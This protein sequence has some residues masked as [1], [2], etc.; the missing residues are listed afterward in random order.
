MNDT[1]LKEIL[2]EEARLGGICSEGYGQM[3]GYDRDGLIRYY[4]ANPDWCMERKFPSLELLNREF[5]D[6]EDKGIYVGRRF[7]GEVL[8]KRQVYIFHNCTGTVRIGWDMENAIIPML[9]CANACDLKIESDG[10]PNPN[11]VSVPVYTFG[12]N[13]IRTTSDSSVR[14]TVYKEKESVSL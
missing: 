13:R 14:F 11:P 7:D 3:R 6:I 5:S 9:Y 4:L 2:M 12:K 8:N 1:Q 10:E